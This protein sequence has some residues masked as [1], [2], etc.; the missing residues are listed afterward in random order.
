MNNLS[1]ILKQWEPQVARSNRA[2]ILQDIISLYR[3]EQETKLRKLKNIERYKKWLR[4]NRIRRTPETDMK[5]KKS[6]L[7]LKRVIR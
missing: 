7:F 3:T 5:F 6:N 2:A 4:E 1:D